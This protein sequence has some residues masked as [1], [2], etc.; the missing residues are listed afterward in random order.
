MANLMIAPCLS[1][2]FNLCLLNGQY[3][4]ELKIAEVV[5]IFDAKYVKRA[6]AEEK[7]KYFSAKEQ[8]ESKQNAR[9]IQQAF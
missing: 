2:K 9:S 8:W 6:V 4:N 5:S 1:R 3:P 7:E